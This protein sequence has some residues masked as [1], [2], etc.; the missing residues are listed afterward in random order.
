MTDIRCG[1][2]GEPYTLSKPCAC[3]WRQVHY[4]QMAQLREMQRRGATGPERYTL[5][6][7]IKCASIDDDKLSRYLQS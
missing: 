3:P 7:E 6:N 5:I 4:R 2:C 1:A